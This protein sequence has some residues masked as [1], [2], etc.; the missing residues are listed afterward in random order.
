[1]AHREEKCPLEEMPEKWKPMKCWDSTSCVSPNRARPR[2]S[3]ETISH[4]CQFQKTNRS[5]PSISQRN[6][7]RREIRPDGTDQKNKQRLVRKKGSLFTVAE[8]MANGRIK[9]YNSSRPFRVSLAN[10][11]ANDIKSKSWGINQSNAHAETWSDMQA[12]KPVR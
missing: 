11:P 9:S 6:Y 8:V 5:K 10:V 3:L 4:L 7:H 12:T 1:M 2:K